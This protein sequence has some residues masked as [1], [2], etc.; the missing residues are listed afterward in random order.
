MLK[1]SDKFPQYVFDYGVS[2]LLT[3]ITVDIQSVFLA[4][5]EV[6]AD[7]RNIFVSFTFKVPAV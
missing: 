7:I 1:V 4:T 5:S 3:E 2:L 6:N